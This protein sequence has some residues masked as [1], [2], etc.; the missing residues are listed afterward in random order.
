MFEVLESV[1]LLAVL[2]VIFLCLLAV[3]TVERFTGRPLETSGED[4]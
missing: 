1:E 2:V 4:D 3:D